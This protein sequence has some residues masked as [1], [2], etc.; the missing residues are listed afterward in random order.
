MF[1]PQADDLN[2][3]PRTHLMHGD[4]ITWNQ[5]E[6]L[7]TLHRDCESIWCLIASTIIN[8]RD[9]QC[10]K[11]LGAICD[12]LAA[13]SV[14]EIEARPFEDELPAYRFVFRDTP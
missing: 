14:Y 10:E 5:K 6:N 8:V 12:M 9:S 13:M 1:H 7:I 4:I 11:M 3:G 2:G